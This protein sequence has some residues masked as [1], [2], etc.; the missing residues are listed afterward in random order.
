[1]LYDK[2]SLANAVDKVGRLIHQG[3]DMNTAARQIAA[4]DGHATGQL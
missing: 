2:E 1:M 3:V 4:K